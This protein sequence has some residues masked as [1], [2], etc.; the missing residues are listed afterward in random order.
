MSIFAEFLLIHSQFALAPTF[1][2]SNSKSKSSG[3]QSG[4]KAAVE[5]SVGDSV[6]EVVGYW[7]IKI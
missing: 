5:E 3:P 6:G 1:R 2:R 7:I 4:M